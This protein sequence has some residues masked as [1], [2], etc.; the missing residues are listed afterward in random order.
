MRAGEA[1][2]LL[3]ISSLTHRLAAP[4]PSN[5]WTNSAC[6]HPRRRK[7]ASICVMRL[8][9]SGFHLAGVWCYTGLPPR[10]VVAGCLFQSRTI[11]GKSISL[12]CMVNLCR[13]TSA[14]SSLLPGRCGL[15][16]SMTRSRTPYRSA[17]Y[18][19]SFSVSIRRHFEALDHYPD[20]LLPLGDVI[21]PN[22]TRPSARNECRR[23]GSSCLET[24]Y[25]SANSD[26][27]PL[28][29]SRGLSSRL[30]KTC[31]PH[32]GQRPRATSSMRNARSASERFSPAL[33]L[34]LRAAA[35]R[36]EDATCIRS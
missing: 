35:G 30:F 32:H 26:A 8:P 28:Q 13:K 33:E 17:R 1:S 31:S 18:Y 2:R 5:C 14:I 22:S 9:C 21:L 4:L 7:S 36:C 20:H 23:A 25:R 29:D 6:Q 34:H 27:D 3:L 24:A 16:R 10:A 15:R 19:H 11:A 12:L